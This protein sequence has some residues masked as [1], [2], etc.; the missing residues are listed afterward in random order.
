MRRARTAIV[1]AAGADELASDVRH[2]RV[3]VELIT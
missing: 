3:G 2:F 1:P